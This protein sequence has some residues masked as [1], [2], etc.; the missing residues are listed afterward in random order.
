MNA[1]CRSNAPGTTVCRVVAGMVIAASMLSIVGCD[2]ARQTE[3]AVRTD[4]QGELVVRACEQ[5]EINDLRVAVNTGWMGS[6]QTVWAASGEVS[7]RSGDELVL[8][9]APPN[10]LRIDRA[11]GG[12][13]EGASTVSLSITGDPGGVSVY[14]L[15]RV[16]SDTWLR[17]DGEIDDEPC[18]HLGDAG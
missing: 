17:W 18:D 10:G 3:F 5:M 2:R 15:A 16:S 6:A 13:L 12:S 1:D 7:L 9:G 8:M 4:G 14:E 11:S